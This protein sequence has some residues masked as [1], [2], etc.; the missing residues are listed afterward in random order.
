[1]PA[2]LRDERRRVGSMGAVS[3]RAAVGSSERL[4]AQASVIT[5]S[6]LS[7]WA[8]RRI[9]QSTG[10]RFAGRLSDIR[11]VLRFAQDGRMKSARDCSSGFHLRPR[12]G[13]ARGSIPRRRARRETPGSDSSARSR[14]KLRNDAAPRLPAAT[15][16]SKRRRRVRDLLPIPRRA[17]QFRTEEDEVVRKSRDQRHPI[18]HRTGRRIQRATSA[19]ETQASHFTFAGKMKKM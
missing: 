2:I 14:R 13:D 7:S 19:A 17:H 18:G 11:E 10:R 6:R 5:D 8:Q 16:P 12:W 9:S 1:M 3:G 15:F 4:I